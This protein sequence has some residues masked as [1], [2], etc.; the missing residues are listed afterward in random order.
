VVIRASYPG[1]A[2]LRPTVAGLQQ[3]LAD[4]ASFGF[5]I[6]EGA[7]EIRE[8]PLEDWGQS[9]KEHFKP[10]P[11]GKRL[12]I[13]PPWEEGPFPPDRQLLRI[14]PA[15]AFGTGHHAT[16]RMC[17]E[18][19]EGFMKQWSSSAPPIVLD[20]GTGT[21][22]L[23]IAAAALGAG[24]VVAL[25]TDPDA[26]DAA[27]KNLAGHPVASRVQ[28]IQGGIDRLGASHRF[29]LITANLDTKTLRPLFSFL[30]ALLSPGGRIIASG[31]IIED[32]ALVTEACQ[33]ARLVLVNREIQEGWLC[34]TLKSVS[35]V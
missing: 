22:I 21:G 8:L 25:D 5:P 34:L 31:I 16:T 18:A 35:P 30:R 19:L 12:I 4:L 20:L 14:D 33:T 2:A 1:S 11:V 17:L 13:A 23:A 15:M 24:T 27:R 3:F 26:C 9:W 32:E 7:I 29:D 6:M 10:L 28:V